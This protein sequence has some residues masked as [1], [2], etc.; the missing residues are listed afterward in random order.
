VRLAE[1]LEM[2]VMI[3]AAT[4]EKIYERY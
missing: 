1:G 3:A 4:E 2:A